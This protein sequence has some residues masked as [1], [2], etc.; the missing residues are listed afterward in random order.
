MKNVFGKQES[1][2]LYNEKGDLVYKFHTDSDGYW[3][4]ITYDD[5]GNQLTFKDSKGYWCEHTYDDKGNELTYKNSNGRWYEYTYDDKDNELTFKDSK[6]K[7]RGFDIPE[8]T[9]EELTKKVGE[10]FKIKK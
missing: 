10:E 4:E 2:K 1:L 3:C 7:L 8:Y 5:K 9:M 6:G